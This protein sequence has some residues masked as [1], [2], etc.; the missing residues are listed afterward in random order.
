ML[1]IFIKIMKEIFAKQSL[2][3]FDWD[4]KSLKK[5]WTEKY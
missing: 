2:K 5:K 1:D 4:D 3:D